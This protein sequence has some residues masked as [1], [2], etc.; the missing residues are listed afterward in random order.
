MKRHPYADLG[1]TIAIG[2]FIIT[3]INALLFDF[4]IVKAMWFV[5]CI[6]YFVVSYKFPSD[7]KQLRNCTHALLAVT[8]LGLAATI[9]FDTNTQPKAHAFD[10]A[11]VDSTETEDII[12][13]DKDIPMTVEIDTLSDD[14]TEAI[15]FFADSTAMIAG[16]T[17]QHHTSQPTISE[18][19]E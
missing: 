17:T 6:A 1:L 12:L 4:T 9:L 14:S 10:G 15:D 3:L 18:S 7:S 11:A 13:E 8:V 5:V 19:D 2:L 16:D